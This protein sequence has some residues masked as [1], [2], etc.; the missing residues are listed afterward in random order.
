MGAAR[1]ATMTLAA[2]RDDLT[3]I[4]TLKGRE[5]YT[6]RWLDYHNRAGLPWPVIVGDGAPSDANE[7]LFKQAPQLRANY[8]RYA[9]SD[10]ISFYRKLYDL[11]AAVPTPY[12]MLSDNDDF[13]LPSG[14]S[15]SIRFLDANPD[16]VSCS[17]AILGVYITDSDF[18]E[19]DRIFGGVPYKLR[20][21]Y[22]I[23]VSNE[24]D[25]EARTIGLLYDYTPTWY[26]VHRRDALLKAFSDLVDRKISD[27]TVMELLVAA[28]LAAIGRQ[29]IDFSYASYLRQLNSSQG[30]GASG[31]LLADPLSP[32]VER[33]I[34]AMAASL[35]A[36]IGGKTNDDT[37]KRIRAAIRGYRKKGMRPR[38][39]FGL[40]LDRFIGRYL[41]TLRAKVPGLRPLFSHFEKRK[42]FGD[43]RANGATDSSISELQ[44]ELELAWRCA[45][46]RGPETVPNAALPRDR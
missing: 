1:A 6:P 9:D 36:V 42:V 45:G 25:A 2:P 24:T 4:L 7:A 22:N 15:R 14:V 46:H 35:V 41:H 19:K 37:A 17:G 21:I 28:E 26:A 5:D 16:Y 18:A 29:K 3:I 39:S 40:R 27:V 38:V 20:S 34:D 13:V 31:G 8:R 23:P 10:L 11:V 44:D 30:S 12:V 43:M 32:S 33:D